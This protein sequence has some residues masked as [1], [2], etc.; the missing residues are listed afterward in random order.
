MA[1]R[2]LERKDFTYDAA[3]ASAGDSA[4]AL[5]IHAE[6]TRKF[7]PKPPPKFFEVN[8]DLAVVDTLWHVPLDDRT[9]FARVIELPC[10]NAFEKPDWRL[11]ALGTR[12]FRKDKFTVSNLILQEYDYF[13]VRGDFVFYNGYRLQIINVVLEPQGYWG[14]T[15]VWLGLVVETTIAPQGDARPMPDV[16]IA[17]PSEI[18]QNRPLPEI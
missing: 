7:A 14:Q 8:R 10:I 5:K 17:A 1:M 6:Y 13:P 11:T 16:S 12:P 2:F 9:K 4:V 15:N 3:F 18:R